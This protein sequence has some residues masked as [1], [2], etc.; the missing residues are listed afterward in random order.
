MSD[1]LTVAEPSDIHFYAML[2]RRKALKLEINGLQISRGLSAARAIRAELGVET[3]DKKK[4][5]AEFTRKL[6][7]LRPGMDLKE[8]DY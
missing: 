6:N 5:Y 4:L 1:T 3:R 8:D 2:V 7:E